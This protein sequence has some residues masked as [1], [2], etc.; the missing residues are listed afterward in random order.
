[1][2]AS[3]RV[4]K[5]ITAAKEKEEVVQNSLLFIF[6]KKYSLTKKVYLP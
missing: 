3:K 6:I 4:V 1:L 5:N 2:F